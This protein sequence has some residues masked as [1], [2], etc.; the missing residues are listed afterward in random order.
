MGKTKC[1]RRGRFPQ[2]EK[3]RSQDEPARGV[4][5]LPMAAWTSAM[6]CVDSAFTRQRKMASEACP[7][8]QRV[9]HVGRKVGGSPLTPVARGSSNSTPLLGHATGKRSA[10][11][12]RFFTRDIDAKAR[13]EECSSRKRE[14][15]ENT[16]KGTAA[17]SLFSRF[18]SFVLS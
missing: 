1:R 16:K 2:V 5:V 11:R 8:G 15:R 7:A 18:H 3:P 4:R 13:K 17:A 14:I 12:G 10:F 6:Q 9:T